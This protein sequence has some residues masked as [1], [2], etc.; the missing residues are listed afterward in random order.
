MINLSW[1]ENVYIGVGVFK[2]FVYLKMWGLKV[3]LS[4][5]VFVFK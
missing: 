5:F 2:E 3:C 1:I 4:F